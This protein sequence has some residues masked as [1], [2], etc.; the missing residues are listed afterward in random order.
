[1]PAQT[2]SNNRRRHVVSLRLNATEFEQLR[3]LAWMARC[4]SRAELL[5]QLLN[6]AHEQTIRDLQRF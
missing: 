5:R 6:Q 4:R 1:M 2:G 3:A